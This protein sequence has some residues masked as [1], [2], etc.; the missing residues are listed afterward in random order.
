VPRIKRK[1]SRVT[2]TERRTCESPG[3]EALAKERCLQGNCGQQHCE[4]HKGGHSAI[5]T[6]LK[7]RAK[8]ARS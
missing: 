5:H 8:A 7:Q 3:C 6:L 4:E 1:W 2:S